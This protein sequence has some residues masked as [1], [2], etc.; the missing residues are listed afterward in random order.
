MDDL[1]VTGR[2]Q[3]VI[4]GMHHQTGDIQLVALYIQVRRRNPRMVFHLTDEMRPG[5]R[6]QPH[7]SGETA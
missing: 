2:H 7:E 4:L 1:G 3:R 5:L 6:R